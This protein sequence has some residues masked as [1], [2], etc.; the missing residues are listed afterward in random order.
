MEEK[1]SFTQQTTIHTADKI[2]SMKVK[3]TLP[4]MGIILVF[5]YSDYR[6]TCILYNLYFSPAYSITHI[7][8]QSSSHVLTLLQL[9]GPEPASLP[10]PWDSPGK[11]TG[12]GC[13]SLLQG[14]F[15]TQGS[16]LG[17]LHCR[18]ILSWLSLLEVVIVI[19][20]GTRALIPSFL[21]SFI[22]SVLS[23]YHILHTARACLSF[24]QNFTSIRPGTPHPY[25]T[26]NRYQR[27]Q[28]SVSSKSS[29]STFKAG[30]MINYI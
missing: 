4:T 7:T 16:N 30:S 12:V 19:I 22:H 6:Q 9:H 18:K 20:T 2:K 25:Y 3:T 26:L 8:C 14:I 1:L 15:P 5:R 28:L 17:L 27:K 29:R 24:M 10:C 11:N 13:H 23:T 21:P